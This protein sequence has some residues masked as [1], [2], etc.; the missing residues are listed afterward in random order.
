MSSE[1]KDTGIYLPLVE[2][3]YSIQ[4]EGFHTG[5]AAFFL[6]IGGCDVGCSWCDTKFAWDPAQWEMIHINSIIC[7]VRD[8]GADS[9]VITGGEP[10]MYNLDPLC[11]ELKALNIKTYLETSGSHELTGIWDWICL[12]P[13]KNLPP[14][15]NIC[16]LAGELKVIIESEDDFKWAE[17]YREKVKPA[18]KL[19]LQP[20]WSNY[21]KIMPQVVEYVKK[22]TGW[23]ISLQSHK[24]MGIP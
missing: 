18:C 23:S 5:K 17:Q 2:K 19:Y 20:E 1:S 15:G 12:S 4:G 14:T 24:F 16:S 7:D 22:H 10:L 11:S 8:S 21:K 6:R 13:K 3:F 9:V